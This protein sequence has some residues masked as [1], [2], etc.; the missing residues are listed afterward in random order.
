MKRMETKEV[1]SFTQVDI[2]ELRQA[3][4]CVYKNPEDYPDKCV[5]RIFEGE[6]PT[7]IIITRET[8]DELRKDIKE[9]FPYMFPI[10]RSATDFKSVVE[11][12]I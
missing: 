6:K 5:A 2:R 8:I 7:N 3:I 12:W 9:A 10:P 1:K 11:S 4:I